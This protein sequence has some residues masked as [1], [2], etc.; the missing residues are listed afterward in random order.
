M[1]SRVFSHCFR[2]TNC[3]LH[4]RRFGSRAAI[5]RKLTL[6]VSP[7]TSKSRVIEALT[8]HRA[9]ASDK[10]RAGTVESTGHGAAILASRD[11]T[12]WL[13]DESFMSNLLEA[14]FKSANGGQANLP[15]L[16]VLS[17]VTDG[18]SP[19]RLL[20]E[21][22]TGFSILYG[23][24]TNILPG[25][26]EREGFESVSED[27]ASSVSFITNPL[28]GDS[29][30]LEITLPLANTIFQ[31]GRRS[32]LYASKWQSND[33]GRMTLGTMN[34]KSTQKI[35]MNLGSVNHTSSIV[36]LLPLTPPRKIVAGLGNIVRQVEVDGSTTPASQELETLIPQVFDARSER[37]GASSSGPIGVW[38]WVIP[39]HVVEAKKLLE[40]KVF[41]AGSSQTEAD[42]ALE[43]TEAL[44]SLLSSGCRLHK[45]LS[46]GG[47]WGLKQ[48]LL[49]LD[50]ETSY[51]QPEQDDIE[52]FIRSFQERDSSDQSEGLV[53]PGSYL[54]FCIEPYWTEEAVKSSNLLKSKRSLTLGVAPNHD[55]DSSP[56]LSSEGV[57]VVEGHFGATSSTGLFLRTVPDVPSIGA[58]DET[59]GAYSA[60]TTKVDVPRSYFSV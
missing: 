38:C 21:P 29:R 10:L 22:Q 6:A 28:A 55:Q 5:S 19:H 3:R 40:L 16:D 43:A 23:S 34:Q 39:P 59:A 26:W 49:S 8:T 33:M 20:G 37:Y 53:T 11:F 32:T 31:N 36:P 30:P 4:A 46:G 15:G 58:N 17:G 52:M 57:E 60:Y 47:G 45:I 13:E 2:A 7:Q 27:K 54:M 48:G 56:Q 50:P 42:L 51:A 14:L 25:L 9:S 24:S 44:S 1:R 18:L 41:Q 35:A 12:T